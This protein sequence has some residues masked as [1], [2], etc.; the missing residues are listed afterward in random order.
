MV[1]IFYFRSLRLEIL[2]YVDGTLP[3][4]RHSEIRY[5]MLEDMFLEANG[6]IKLASDDMMT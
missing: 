3:I 1:F 5:S 6:I 2:T 4:I